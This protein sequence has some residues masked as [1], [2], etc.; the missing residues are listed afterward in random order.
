MAVTGVA[1][2]ATQGGLAG[3]AVRRMGT[4]A[5]IVSGLIF[6][7]VCYTGMAVSPW[8]SMGAILLIAGV[9]G[10]ALWQP[11]ATAIVSRATDPDRQGAVL[12]AA[13][14]SGS[15][16]RVAGPVFGGILFS[17]VGPWAP[18]VFAGLFMLPAAWLGFRAAEALRAATSLE[19]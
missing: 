15:L 10:H 6:A 1:S 8:A 16:A 11:A 19:T 7:A 4:E 14:A 9:V 13:S 3:I 18:L 12:G 5:T 2:A 17:S